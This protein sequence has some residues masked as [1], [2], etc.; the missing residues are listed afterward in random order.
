MLFK[1]SVGR[2]CRRALFNLQEVVEQRLK[3]Q[4]KGNTERHIPPKF[5]ILI[6]ADATPFWKASATRGDVYVD[7]PGST[8]WVGRPSSWTV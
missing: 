3:L 2:A 6:C 8:W 7:L 1:P 5:N 4:Y